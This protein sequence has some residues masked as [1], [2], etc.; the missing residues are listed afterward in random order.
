MSTVDSVIARLKLVAVCSVAILAVAV[1]MFIFNRSPKRAED[2][3][4]NAVFVKGSKAGWWQSCA[5][6]DSGAITCRIVSRTGQIL[7]DQEFLPY[8]GGPLPATSEL[9]LDPKNRYSGVYRVCLK[10]GRILLDR[11]RVV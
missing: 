10:N 3:P 8:D 2:V 4:T 7:V 9:V 11:K 6:I 5:K 1:Y